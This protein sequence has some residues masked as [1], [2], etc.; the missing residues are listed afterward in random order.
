MNQRKS[1]GSFSGTYGSI[2]KVNSEKQVVL[3]NAVQSVNID[4]Q[5]V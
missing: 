3:E 4:I 5:L 2:T 1:G